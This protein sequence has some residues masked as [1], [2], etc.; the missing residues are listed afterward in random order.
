M[1]VTWLYAFVQTFY[2][3]LKIFAFYYVSHNAIML[4]QNNTAPKLQKYFKVL[5]GSTIM[6]RKDT[7][8]TAD[9]KLE[10]P[11]QKSVTQNGLKSS[12]FLKTIN[13]VIY[14][15]IFARAESLVWTFLQLRPSGA[16]LL[17]WCT[18]FSLRWL[19]LLWITGSRAVGLSSCTSSLDVHTSSVVP[20]HVGSSQTRGRSCVSCTGR[21]ALHH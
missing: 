6:Q 8:S 1:L 18:D 4:I 12:L 10:Q 3:T 14:L 17:L 15:F 5:I 13:Y 21:W 7:F 19:L 20:Q 9:V 11:L 2:Y 16:T